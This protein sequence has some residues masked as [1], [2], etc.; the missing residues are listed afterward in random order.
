MVTSVSHGS[1]TLNPNGG[2]SYT[3]T[4]GYVGPDSFTYQANDGTA[5]S[6]TATVSL[7]VTATNTAPVAAN[8]SYATPKNTTLTCAPGVLANDTDAESN[9][10]TAA[11]VT[12]VSH[13]SLTSTPTAASAIPH[14]RLCRPRQLHLPGQ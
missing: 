14:G 2:F 9:P 4:A 12:S 11:V 3:P 8:D 6:N 7:T 10:L 13:G 5:N 1:L